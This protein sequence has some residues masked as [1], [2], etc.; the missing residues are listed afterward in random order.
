MKLY[1]PAIL[2]AAISNGSIS[3]SACPF[4][5][6][7][8]GEMPNDSAH[9]NLRRRRLASLSQDEVVR[10]KLGNIITA[11]KQRRSLDDNDCG[12][13]V[14]TYEDL[15]EDLSSMAS[16]IGNAGDRGHFIGGIVRL[17]AVSFRGIYYLFISK[18]RLKYL[19]T[20]SHVSFSLK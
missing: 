13:S 19:V 7:N 5:N 18:P 16:A 9:T 1:L 17:A 6:T 15:R 12:L 14:E 4:S 3:A 10:T 2:I 8:D 11:S 20:I